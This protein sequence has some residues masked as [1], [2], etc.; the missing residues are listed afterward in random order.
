[1]AMKFFSSLKILSLKTDIVV[2]IDR[3]N[4]HKKEGQQFYNIKDIIMHI[5]ILYLFGCKNRVI[6]V[7]L[8]LKLDYARL[9]IQNSLIETGKQDWASKVRRVGLSV[10]LFK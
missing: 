8:S 3:F 5:H 2:V 9:A 7:W 4:V 10:H 1:M 6:R